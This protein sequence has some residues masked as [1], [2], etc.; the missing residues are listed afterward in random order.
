MNKND[1]T[2]LPGFTAEASL[3][4]TSERYQ[5]EAKQASS[6]DGQAVIAQMRCKGCVCGGDVCVCSD[7]TVP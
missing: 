6:T 1:K 2:R 4:K 3:Y 5:G 7:C